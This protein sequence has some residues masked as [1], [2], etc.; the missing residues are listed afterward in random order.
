MNYKK[1]LFEKIVD[2]SKDLVPS[3]VYKAIEPINFGVNYYSPSKI[4]ELSSLRYSILST[5][6]KNM[7]P[8]DTILYNKSNFNF[9][10]FLCK[11]FDQ[12]NINYF[13]FSG[14]G[15]IICFFSIG[16]FEKFM[17]EL[18]VTKKANFISP[19]INFDFNDDQDS[20]AFVTKIYCYS[21]N[22]LKTYSNLERINSLLN[23][24]EY[25]ILQNNDCNINILSKQGFA[26]KQ[27]TYKIE[28]INDDI[29]DFY[30]QDIVSKTDSLIKTI[31]EKNKGII[32]LHGFKG[33]GKTTYIK[34]LINKSNKSFYYING[35]TASSFGS[36][37]FLEFI[38]ENGK[39]S[40]FI[41]E[42]MEFLLT[43][44]ENRPSSLISDIL[45]ASDG[46]L[47]DIIS[48][49]FIFTFNTIM[50]N[51]DSAFLRPSRLLYEQEFKKLPYEKA[52]NLS[53]KINV[54][55]PEEKEY[56]L[57]ELFELKNSISENR[58]KKFRSENNNIVTGF[59]KP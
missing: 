36:G 9:Y 5:Y 46:I 35:E 20:E 47:S 2:I 40:V 30:N 37:S 14:D 52:L 19:V 48:P 39:K 51:I 24:S 33:C 11:M 58:S 29:L 7:L 25:E 34:Y 13:N 41:F 10:K 16:D 21:I 18:N 15:G 49:I 3:H 59:L 55:L 1:L 44:R 6:F 23:L 43:S 32:L 26:I 4:F 56:S 45:N 42:D 28:S 57:A 27:S 53:K 50:E 31:N 54:V 17:F 38:Y 12:I 22:Y 8:H